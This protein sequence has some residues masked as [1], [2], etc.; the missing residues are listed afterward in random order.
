MAGTIE[1]VND[2]N[3]LLR[4]ELAAIDTYRHAIDMNRKAH[5]QDPRFQTLTDMLH[6]HE[7]AASR[8]REL[9]QRMGG[10]AANGAGAWGAQANSVLGAA[11]LLGEKTALR[12][13]REGEESGVKDYRALLQ[14]VTAVVDPEV[15]DVCALNMSREE[16]HVRQLDRLIAFA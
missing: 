15:L 5:G 3:G 4:D 8:L 11:S 10:T 14:E 1:I 9:V 13:L 7:Q 12:A 2:L 6:D 16:E